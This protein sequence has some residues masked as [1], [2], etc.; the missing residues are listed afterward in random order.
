MLERW[1]VSRPSRCLQ[2]HSGSGVHLKRSLLEIQPDG[3][4]LSRLAVQ[5][6]LDTTPERIRQGKEQLQFEVVLT[7]A[8]VEDLP[9]A[10]LAFDDPKGM[11]H[12]GAEVGLRRLNQIQKRA[13]LC[14]LE[15]LYVDR[16]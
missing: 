14:L 2:C 15:A 5:I 12:F 10:K 16:A 1:A 11:F 13:L 8:P 7:D 4:D 3:G 9:E 6:R